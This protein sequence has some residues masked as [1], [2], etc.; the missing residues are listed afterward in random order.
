MFVLPQ[1]YVESWYLAGCETSLYSLLEYC[2]IFKV[3]IKSSK[4]AVAGGPNMSQ[5]NGLITSEIYKELSHKK[6]V[7]FSPNA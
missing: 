6:S 3:R 1:L 4:D 5:S 2:N 7:H